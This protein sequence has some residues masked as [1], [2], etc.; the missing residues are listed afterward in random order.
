[1][2]FHLQIISDIVMTSYYQDCFTFIQLC[3]L[4]SDKQFFVDFLL[5]LIKKHYNNKAS[6]LRSTAKV[7]CKSAIQ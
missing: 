6:L 1:M 7:V 3:H 4:L 5:L 2:L